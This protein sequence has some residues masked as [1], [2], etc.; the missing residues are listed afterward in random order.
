MK[1]LII[2]MVVILFCLWIPNICV[3]S[4]N[5]PFYIGEKRIDSIYAARYKYGNEWL[6]SD[7]SKAGGNWGFEPVSSI[8]NGVENSMVFS[9]GGSCVGHGQEGSNTLDETKRIIWI[10]DVSDT[11]SSTKWNYLAYSILYSVQNN[12]H[13]PKVASPAGQK[14]K[15]TIA[16][17]LLRNRGSGVHAQVEYNFATRT[18]YDSNYGGLNVG[19]VYYRNAT[20]YVNSRD[21][22]ISLNT[23]KMEN[24]KK[25]N[26]VPQVTWKER[27]NIRIY[28]DRTI[29]N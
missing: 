11:G 16:N 2:S 23:T 24:D 18:K 3:A 25:N 8:H 5:T 14:G 9:T 21:A 17:W 4:P 12:E 6:D 26:I 10:Y 20:D 27:G 19:G 1:K 7:Y 13:S 22:K 29:S 28:S 15:E